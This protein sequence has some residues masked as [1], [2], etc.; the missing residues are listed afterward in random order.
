MRRPVS[1][2]RA[3]SVPERLFSTEKETGRI[4]ALLL[5]FRDSAAVKPEDERHRIAALLTGYFWRKQRRE[6]DNGIA[7]MRSEKERDPS[8]A[9]PVSYRNFA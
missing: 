3:A 7:F 6:T 9:E 8:C 1:G 5:S 2:S 4:D